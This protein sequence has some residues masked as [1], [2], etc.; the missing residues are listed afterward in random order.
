MNSLRQWL[1]SHKHWGL[2]LGV[3]AIFFALAYGVMPIATALTFDLDEGI[4]LA[5]ATLLNQGYDLYDPIWSD[6]PPLMTLLLAAWLK[7]FGNHIVAARLLILSFATG[8]ISA[9]YQSL[10]LSVGTQ[11]ALLGTLA[12]TLTFGFLR[13]SV[14]VMQGIPALALAMIAVFGLLHA[15][16]P[17]EK[18]HLLPTR[19]E[20]LVSGLCFGLS[21]QIKLYT[22]LLLPA[23]LFQ[24]VWGTKTTHWRQAIQRQGISRIAVWLLGGVASFAALMLLNPGFSVTQLLGLH[25]NATTQAALQREPSWLIL[26]MFLAQDLDATLLSGVG[27]WRVLHHKPQLPLF[28]LVWLAT[29]LVGLANYQPIWDH[30]YPLV[31]VPVVWLAVYGASQAQ[32]QFKQ[33]RN[34]WHIASRWKVQRVEALATGFLVFA[35]ALAPLKL[36]V[37]GVS[38]HLVLQES[39]QNVAVVQQIKALQPKTH[40]LFTDLPIVAFYTHLNVP[41]E[42][43][44]FSTKRLKSGELSP[45]ILIK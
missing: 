12:L 31:A 34:L 5:K 43:A 19:L 44:V 33:W 16:H 18:S 13:F 3:P 15:T 8:L 40:W 35:I 1:R 22:L 37:L 20:L 2:N 38:N 41:P 10:R 24:L 23:C 26:L 28:P 42:L 32:F 7:L 11:F 45:Q 17:Q 6:Q 25:F 36:A 30:Y 27:I 29:V 39:V 4:E 9:F 21:V 14:S